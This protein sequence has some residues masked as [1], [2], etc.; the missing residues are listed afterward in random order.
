M[1]ELTGFR[2][3][4][5]WFD[6]P[7]QESLLGDVLAAVRV[8]PAQRYATPNGRM[9]VRM[10][11]FGE[12]GWI[13]DERGYRYEP[14]RPDNG[15]PWPPIPVRLLELWASITA[16]AQPPDSCL[17]NIYDR[18]A[19]MGLHQDRD[20]RDISHPVVSVSL[21]DVAIFRLGGTARTDPTRTLRLTSGD[22]C[23]LS[24]PARLAFHGVDRIVAGTSS[25][26][27]GGG[28]INLTLR[29]AL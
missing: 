4:A 8:A 9:S 11:A 21:G 29:R 24:G 25:L 7:A 15:D 19:R 23:M 18:D 22:V 13:S 5:E 1:I 14:R 3:A 6:R 10:T 12:V 26:I 16:G 17:V 20:E 28:R 27:P 2:L